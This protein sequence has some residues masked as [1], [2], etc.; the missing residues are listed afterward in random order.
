MLACV[1]AEEVDVCVW[2]DEEMNET[3]EC[4]FIVKVCFTVTAVS[5]F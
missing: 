3:V 2:L 5:S 4:R 1:L